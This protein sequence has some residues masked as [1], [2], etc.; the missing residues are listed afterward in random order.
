[1]LFRSSRL[2]VLPSD[3]VE[4][5][6]VFRKSTKFNR[7]PFN[8]IRLLKTSTN[9]DNLLIS[10][11]ASIIIY[12]VN[13]NKF[14]EHLLLDLLT[15]DN[16]K[17]YKASKDSDLMAKYKAKLDWCMATLHEFKVDVKVIFDLPKPKKPS[18]DS[19][20]HLFGVYLE[21]Y[22]FRT[23]SRRN[24]RRR[25][26]V[27]ASLP[28]NVKSKVSSHV[29]ILTDSPF[30]N[31][32]EK[33][34]RNEMYMRKTD[35]ILQHKNFVAQ[36]TP[37]KNLRVTINDAKPELL[38]SDAGMGEKSD[39]K[40]AKE[41][42]FK[43][44]M[45]F[46]TTSSRNKSKVTLPI[47]DTFK[48]GAV[49]APNN[50]QNSSSEDFSS[51]KTVTETLRSRISSIIPDVFVSTNHESSGSEA[52]LKNA[53]SN[54]SAN[55]TICDQ[56]AAEKGLVTVINI[57]RKSE[58]LQTDENSSK[59][60]KNDKYEYNIKYVNKKAYSRPTIFSSIS[61]SPTSF[62]VST[63]ATDSQDEV[64][65]SSSRKNSI[66]SKMS[67]SLSG[68]SN[69]GESKGFI[70]SLFH[71]SKQNGANTMKGVFSEKFENKNVE[72]TAI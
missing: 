47:P 5:E 20:T 9:S 3:Q 16:F 42:R 1:V 17:F 36:T 69:S 34:D 29:S 14:F 30:K 58:S 4:F 38:G 12:D 37:K 32:S 13:K 18:I 25:T 44:I 70:H 67:G 46:A 2:A 6:L 55:R 53:S 24:F 68:S 52:S 66:F 72:I 40:D 19:A 50:L 41:N 21:Q 65:K 10:Q 15:M 56:V 11:V 48:K 23:Y 63:E 51:S 54:S 59:I 26:N 60:N 28:S 62:T 27:S 64:P 49:G 57:R 8:R 43:K 61:K 39:A 31:E 45:K 7:L 22:L 35:T 33:E 71:A